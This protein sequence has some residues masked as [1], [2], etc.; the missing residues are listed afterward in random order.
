MG[1]LFR[2]YDDH[3]PLLVHS[4]NLIGMKWIVTRA[5]AYGIVGC[6]AYLLA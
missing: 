6:I 2:I 1:E 3:C 4:G 5:M